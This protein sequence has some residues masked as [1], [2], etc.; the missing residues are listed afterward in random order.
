MFPKLNCKRVFIVLLLNLAGLA[1]CGLLA[2]SVQAASR[3]TAVVTVKAQAQTAPLPGTPDV[4]PNDAGYQANTSQLNPLGATLWWGAITK[5]TC[6]AS[7]LEDI[8]SGITQQPD[9]PVSSALDY[10]P[11]DSS[12]G[13]D[14]SGHDTHVGSIA[15]ANINDKQGVAGFSNC[16][17]ISAKAFVDGVNQNEY[18]ANAINDAANNA[19]V[20]V[21]LVEFQQCA[22]TD[23]FGDLVNAIKNAAAHDKVV[24]VPAGNAPFCSD[25]A[26]AVFGVSGV[27]TVTSI[28]FL[29][30]SR[31][32]LDSTSYHGTS[33][34]TVAA[35]GNLPA[36]NPDGSV[37]LVDG[38]SYA[39]PL[40]AA[41][42]V[43][44]RDMVPGLSAAST[45]QY[46][47]DSGA[48]ASDFF[49]KQPLDDYCHCYINPLQSLLDAGWQQPS[50]TV[51]V[52]VT[53]RGK[54][55]DLTYTTFSCTTAC[56]GKVYDGSEMQVEATPSS[57]WVFAGWQGSSCRKQNLCT[58]TATGVVNLKPKF[59]KR[60]KVKI[61]V[62]VASG[63]GTIHISAS[64]VGQ[65]RSIAVVDYGQPKVSIL[66]IPAKGLHFVRWTGVCAGQKDPCILRHVMPPNKQIK[67]YSK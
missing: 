42:A 67:V 11:G 15:R 16:P 12:P 39:A 46:I 57:G 23:G 4:S 26:A 19:L 40:V 62:V 33:V 59:V 60:P 31:V 7:A 55:E 36:D 14:S 30:G 13:T 63:K 27:I 6:S 65:Q 34:A 47:S 53:G 9:L 38:T 58:V 25:L 56:S 54:V 49:T 61:M 37:S 66:F 50:G 45:V 17:L 1:G 8:G 29:G 21:I 48:K 64:G 18:F 3:P 5:H 2:S 22:N 41:V 52:K 51:N 35:P 10:V 32:Q 43:E 24:V 28:H 20:K 44:M